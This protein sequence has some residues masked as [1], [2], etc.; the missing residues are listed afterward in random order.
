MLVGLLGDRSA[1]TP[2]CSATLIDAKHGAAIRSTAPGLDPGRA[3]PKVNVGR[4]INESP[5]CQLWNNNTGVE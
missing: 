5:R 4:G 3:A 2:N 1:K